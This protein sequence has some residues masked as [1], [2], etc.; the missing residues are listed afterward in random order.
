MC[1]RF[2]FVTEKCLAA[3][4]HN[5]PSY[6][7]ENCSLALLPSCLPLFLLL[8]HAQQHT[9]IASPLN[10][11]HALG[12]SEFFPPMGF[13]PRQFSLVLLPLMW[14]VCVV[15][16]KQY[17]SEAAALLDSRKKRKVEE[18]LSPPLAKRSF[19]HSSSAGNSRE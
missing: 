1:E 3:T 13:S 5:F 7:R 10:S 9:V 4:S 14:C 15:N 6:H 17:M 8:S 18:R 16:S 19:A 2:Y 11:V 12:R